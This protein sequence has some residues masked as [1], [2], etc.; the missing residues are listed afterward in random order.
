MDPKG[1]VF[2]VMNFAARFAPLELCSS[3]E[4]EKM[5]EMRPGCTCSVHV[6]AYNT[7]VSAAS[8]FVVVIVCVSV[9]M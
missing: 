5:M 2:A 9:Y 4:M 1:I 8:N 7:Y 6:H 3:V